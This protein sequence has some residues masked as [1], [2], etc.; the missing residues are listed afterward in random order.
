MAAEPG[1]IHFGTSHEN[2]PGRSYHAQFGTSRFMKDCSCRDGH[3][4]SSHFDKS[5]S[6]HLGEK[7]FDSNDLLRET[8]LESQDGQHDG[9]GQSTPGIG[10]VGSQRDDS[11]EDENVPEEAEKS[12]GHESQQQ[13]APWT[14]EDHWRLSTSRA[15]A[16]ETRVHD[17]GYGDDPKMIN[18]TSLTRH[19]PTIS[20]LTR[21]RPTFS[22][23]HNGLVRQVPAN[24]R[25]ER[26]LRATAVACRE[27][28]TCPSGGNTMFACEDAD[29]HYFYEMGSLPSAET[30]KAFFTTE[31]VL[32]T[33]Q[34]K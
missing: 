11:F 20:R 15:R 3:F 9:G 6:S 24:P 23:S 10:F 25:R 30:E 27:A 4:S 22:L 14:A 8:T 2:H 31:D 16:A 17:I 34:C 1:D 26:Q 5:D 19:R 7:Y 13:S 29:H 33:N 18:K 28:M 12:R 21:N 32:S